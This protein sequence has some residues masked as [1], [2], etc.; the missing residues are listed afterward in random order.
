MEKAPDFELLDGQGQKRR[1]S[2]FWAE[3]P[4]VLVFYPGDFTPTCTAQLCDYR[5]NLAR[6]SSLGV[7]L[8]GISPDTPEKHADFAGQNGFTFP[9]LCDP[10]GEVIRA[11]RCTSKWTLGLLSRAIC[12]VNRRGEIVWRHVEAVAVTRRTADQLAEVI[13]SLNL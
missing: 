10:K 2:D 3:R 7:S 9:L 6:L 13:Q 4:L 8:V 12:I 11:Y 5:D 1:L